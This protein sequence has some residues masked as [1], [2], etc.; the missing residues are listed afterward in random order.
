MSR[1]TL[2]IGLRILSASCRGNDPKPIEPRPVT[3]TGRSDY[4]FR[5]FRPAVPD[6]RCALLD[7]NP[8]KTNIF[9]IHKALS[10]NFDEYQYNC[11]RLKSLKNSG[12]LLPGTGGKTKTKKDAKYEG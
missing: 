7:C 2:P 3:G 4:R 6:Q 10:D 8:E 9:M 5:V 1:R 12:I 11:T